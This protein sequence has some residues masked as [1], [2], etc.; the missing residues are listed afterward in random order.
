MGSRRSEVLGVDGQVHRQA[1]PDLVDHCRAY[2]VF[3]LADLEHR[4]NQVAAGR[5]SLHNGPAVSARSA[6]RTN[7]LADTV[8]LHVCGHDVRGP[9]LDDFQRDGAVHPDARA[10]VFCHAARHAILANAVG[11]GNGRSRRRQ[12]RLQH[13]EH[14]VL[15]PRADEG[16]GAGFECG[17]R[18]YRCQQRAVTDADF[19]GR[20]SYQFVSGNA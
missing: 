15:L 19:D 18:K 7:R 20:W 11:V 9:E 4:R 10:G 16:L 8:S 6:A 13:G 14:L 2:R 12:L 3:D 5:L 17:R 1:Q